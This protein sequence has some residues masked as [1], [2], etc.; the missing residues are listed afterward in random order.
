MTRKVRE[1]W[2]LWEQV[3][4]TVTPKH[5]IDP[6]TEV[7]AKVK[8][9]SPRA[10]K[11]DSGSSRV[12][13]PH[14]P[15]E[16]GIRLNLSPGPVF[17]DEATSKKIAKGK[18]GIDGKIDLHGLTQNEAY[19]RLYRFVDESFLAGKRTVLVITGKGKLGEGIL[20]AAVPRWLAEPV[21]AD[22]VIGHREAHAKQGGGGA[23]YVRLRN[24]NR[25]A[26]R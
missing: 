10:K 24:K 3:K 22:K 9:R 19:S 15:E 12:I 1:D 4:K 5:P 7:N 26:K 16:P 2:E 18:I 11:S 17:L 23:L 25:K 21:F 13:K 8:S 6:Q 20:R 14:S